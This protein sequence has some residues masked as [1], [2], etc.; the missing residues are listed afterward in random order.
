MAFTSNKYVNLLI[1]FILS[2]FFTA[3]SSSTNKVDVNKSI[4]K[5]LKKNDVQKVVPIFNTQKE[6]QIEFKKS[7]YKENK[8]SYKKINLANE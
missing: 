8:D 2:I 6:E 1:L 4:F 3:C 7:K 5:K